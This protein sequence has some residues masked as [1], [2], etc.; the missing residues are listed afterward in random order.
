[1]LVVTLTPLIRL[2][3]Y[4]SK[5]ALPASVL[6]V[7]VFLQDSYRKML[8]L[9]LEYPTFA[10]YVF[11]LCMAATSVV[12]IWSVT[13]T[14]LYLEMV[15]AKNDLAFIR[16][17]QNSEILFFRATFLFV[18]ISPIAMWFVVNAQ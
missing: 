2:E 4:D 1:M 10:D 8:P 12:F 15:G 9:S 18:I 7:L 14:N 17:R 6:L 16:S 3:H 11:Y 13:N 5:V